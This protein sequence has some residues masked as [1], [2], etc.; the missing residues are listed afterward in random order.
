[1]NDPVDPGYVTPEVVQRVKDAMQEAM[2]EGGSKSP[3]MMNSC[4]RCK[5]LK[6]FRAH[7][8]SFCN[9]CVLKMGELLPGEGRVG[10]KSAY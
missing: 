10:W 4:R 9:R 7:H 8:C 1:V 6:P 3:L 5:L 2:E